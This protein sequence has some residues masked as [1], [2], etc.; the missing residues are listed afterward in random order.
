LPHQFLLVKSACVGI[1]LYSMRKATRCAVVPRRFKNWILPRLLPVRMLEAAV[2]KQMDS[3]SGSHRNREG[4]A[5]PKLVAKHRDGVPGVTVVVSVG[6]GHLV[7]RMCVGRLSVG[8]IVIHI[9]RSLH[10]T[11]RARV[12]ISDECTAIATL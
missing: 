8:L 2:A 9:H 4:Q 5:Q 6:A 11:S 1:R 10:P 3:E 7:A 12:S